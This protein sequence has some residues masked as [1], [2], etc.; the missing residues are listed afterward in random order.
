VLLGLHPLRKNPVYHTL[1]MAYLGCVRQF[2]KCRQRTC[3]IGPAWVGFSRLIVT[4]QA[5]ASLAMDLAHSR[6]H[7]AFTHAPLLAH[8]DQGS[9]GA[10]CGARGSAH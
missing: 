6:P 10:N 4:K 5:G 9:G 2:R 1:T 7:K 3:P 8:F